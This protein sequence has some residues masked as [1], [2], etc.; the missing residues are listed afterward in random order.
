MGMNVQ[1]LADWEFADLGVCSS[2]DRDSCL[3]H[4]S[5][6]VGLERRPEY[7]LCTFV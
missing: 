4:D 1:Q 5:I 3:R 7:L 2:H 6:E